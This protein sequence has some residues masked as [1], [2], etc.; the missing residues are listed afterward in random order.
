MVSR[1]AAARCDGIVDK[2]SVLADRVLDCRYVDGQSSSEGVIITRSRIQTTRPIEALC[3]SNATCLAA[4]TAVAR[5]QRGWRAVGHDIPLPPWFGR[6]GRTGGGRRC[7]RRPPERSYELHEGRNALRARRAR[8]RCST[9]LSAR[10]HIGRPMAAV[11]SLWQLLLATRRA[12]L[13][14]IVFGGGHR[15]G[16]R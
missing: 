14:I 1:T 10:D 2:R 8:T 15:V 11:A 9:G 3:G 16:A 12:R 6:T 5:W 13:S 7:S 4:L